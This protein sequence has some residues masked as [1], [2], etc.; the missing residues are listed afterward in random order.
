M[1]TEFNYQ[2]SDTKK[3]FNGGVVSTLREWD[4]IGKNRAT[5]A[6]DKLVMDA[7]IDHFF[8]LFA[9]SE[10]HSTVDALVRFKETMYDWHPPKSIE[11]NTVWIELEYT[12]GRAKVTFGLSGSFLGGDVAMDYIELFAEITRAQHLWEEANA[13][14]LSKIK[15]PVPTLTPPP[16]PK[17][18][19][20]S[21][22]QTLPFTAIR[23]DIVGG[24]RRHM[25]M[26]VSPYNK[27]GVPI[28]QDT[29]IFSKPFKLTDLQPGDNPIKGMATIQMGPK[30]PIRV[31][32]L[33]IQ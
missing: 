14:M 32:E 10:F 1:S 15:S 22:T 6:A 18:V 19:D 28:Y 27:H 33:D 31:I 20:K 3:V 16:Q 13:D 4:Y 24:S 2:D 12:Y 25:V 8:T 5:W 17:N 11:A 7:Y 21:N 23:V 9:P 29:C 30:N 26:C